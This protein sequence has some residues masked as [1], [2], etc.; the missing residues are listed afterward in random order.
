[1][2]LDDVG[3]HNFGRVRERCCEGRDASGFKP[4][5]YISLFRWFP[6][7]GRPFYRETISKFSHPQTPFEIEAAYLFIANKTKG[8]LHVQVAAPVLNTPCQDLAVA[9]KGVHTVEPAKPSPPPVPRPKFLIRG[10][11]SDE[12][13][14]KKLLFGTEKFERGPRTAIAVGLSLK[15]WPHRPPHLAKFPPISEGP[16]ACEYEDFPFLG[17]T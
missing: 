15:F 13:V 16:Y 4:V 17:K 1:L 2:K 14:D 3:S 8:M 9:F 12:E 5:S 10:R 6:A 11:L 7:S